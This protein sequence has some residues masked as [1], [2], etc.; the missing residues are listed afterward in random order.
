M[1][2]TNLRSVSRSPARR[3]CHWIFRGKNNFGDTQF[4]DRV[5]ANEFV[6]NEKN[7]RLNAE[8]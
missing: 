7:I 6:E 3:I 5:L 1:A 4:R 8:K 2:N